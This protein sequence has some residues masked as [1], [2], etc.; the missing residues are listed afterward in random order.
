MSDTDGGHGA[1]HQAIGKVGQSGAT[2]PNLSI[3]LTSLAATTLQSVE[4]FNES[5]DG[6]QSVL[7]RSTNHFNEV[8]A[9]GQQNIESI[10]LRIN[11]LK[12]FIVSTEKLEQHH[13]SIVGFVRVLEE[14][15]A[16]TSILALNASVEAA[17]AGEQGKGFSVIAK[18]VR[19]LA[20]Q[21]LESSESI[22][23][24]INKSQA[25]GQEISTKA[26]TSSEALT[27]IH[28]DINQ[29]MDS[30]KKGVAT[31]RE[32]E[33]IANNIS[34]VAGALNDSAKKNIM[35]IR[36][37][38]QIG[39]RFGVYM[40]DLFREADF[41][42][43]QGKG[44]NERYIQPKHVFHFNLMNTYP[45]LL[46]EKTHQSNNFEFPLKKDKLIAPKDV[47]SKLLKV[48]KL[49]A[50][51]KS[52]QEMTIKDINDEI[53]PVDVLRLSVMFSELVQ[54]KWGKAVL[55]GNHVMNYERWRKQTEVTP[56]SVLSLIDHFHLIMQNR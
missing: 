15:A 34:S 33:A 41:N 37:S 30:L 53:W 23:Q 24:V 9:L 7:N 28:E 42:E 18:S 19:D 21:S 8:D 12:N 51:S 32:N 27:M 39:I 38:S 16:Q 14:I 26:K 49:A 46:Q 25:H 54:K 29:I 3:D 20:T 43:E 6:L 11:D 17:R 50:P 1:L 2:L 48:M 55:D 52:M 22:K 47:Y 5:I 56:C 31:F 36:D 35:A 4:K 13:Q 45:S 44:I 10:K 40:N